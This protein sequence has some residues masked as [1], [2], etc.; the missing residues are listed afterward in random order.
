MIFSFIGI[1]GFA[2]SEAELPGCIASSSIRTQVQ[3][4]LKPHSTVRQLCRGT[5][6]R[7]RLTDESWYS[8]G[9]PHHAFSR[10]NGTVL[11]SRSD[12][13]AR[14]RKLDLP[15]KRMRIRR[16]MVARKQA[17]KTN[18]EMRSARDLVPLNNGVSF[19][20]L[21][22]SVS[23][24]NLSHTRRGWLGPLRDNVDASPVH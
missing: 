10:I 22:L 17:E 21:N 2:E 14:M 23:N 9:A 4:R 1:E 16:I 24:S 15:R 6:P 3:I 11:T 7:F 13:E 5:S 18:P 12:V 8:N 20:R 19:F